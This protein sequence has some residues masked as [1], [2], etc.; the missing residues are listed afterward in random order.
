ML[1]KRP[2]M[3]NFN[4]LRTNQYF[5]STLPKRGFFTTESKKGFYPHSLR[6]QFRYSHLSLSGL[7]LSFSSNANGEING[8]NLDPILPNIPTRIQQLHNLKSSSTKDDPYDI[9][10][11]GGGATGSGC[12][13]D[14]VTRQFAN[15]KQ[16]KVACIEKGDFASETS[17]RSTKLIWAGIRYLATASAALLDWKLLT[18]PRGTIQEFVAELKMVISCHTERRF[19]LEK[20]QH[21][22]NWVPIGELHSIYLFTM[23]FHFKSQV[24]KLHDF[25]NYL[26]HI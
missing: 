19:M 21:L 25:T 3:F 2:P 5:K 4:R 16:L 12:A 6:S 22:T 17:S 15:N 24:L 11:I 23:L 8:S 14:A 18:S 26:L 7:S 1:P 9:L 13:L 10:I 20:Q